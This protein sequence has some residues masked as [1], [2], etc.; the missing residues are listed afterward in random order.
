MTHDLFILIAYNSDMKKPRTKAGNVEKQIARRIARKRGDVFLRTDFSDIGGYDQVGRALRDLVRKGTLIKIGLGLYA[1]A[2]PS[3][4]GGK[5]TP[6]NG[7]RTLKEGLRRLGIETGPSRADLAYN[8]GRSEQVPTGRVVALRGKRTRRQIGYDGFFLVFERA[9]PDRRVEGSAASR[10]TAAPQAPITVREA[11]RLM[12]EADSYPIL[13]NE[14]W[15]V[16]E[17]MESEALERAATA[18][19]GPDDPPEFAA[20]I[21]ALRN[22][23]LSADERDDIL[24]AIYDLFDPERD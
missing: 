9:R 15:R 7:L 24:S 16:A 22:P 17:R 12:W 19:Q 4:R 14:D 6:M 21:A 5:P 13:G 10:R 2:R 23:K 11:L 1:R 8:S 3:F 18:V 20:W